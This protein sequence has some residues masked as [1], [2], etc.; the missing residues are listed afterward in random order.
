[1]SSL[2]EREYQVIRKLVFERSRINL[3]PDKKELVA[4][5]VNKRLRQLRLDSYADYC[6]LLTASDGED[7]LKDLVDVISTNFTNFFRE[8]SHFDFLRA[9]AL[10]RFT[11]GAKAPIKRLRV[12]SAACSSGE[13]PYSIAI[14]L[15]D[16]FS[17]KDGWQWQVEAA[18]ISTRMLAKAR[19]GIYEAARVI[20][21]NP[22][23]L[24]RYFRK[25]VDSYAGYYRVKAELRGAVRFHHLNLFQP[26]YPFAPGLHAIFCRNVMI[27][28]DRATQEQLVNRLA[29]YLLPGGYLFVGHAESLI[30][31]NHPLDGIEPS[32]YQKPDRQHG[33]LQ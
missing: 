30:S 14:V 27:Y 1:M 7:E 15:A 10:P 16:F 12:W 11:A 6:K 13:E 32:V 19:C 8:R 5:R 17:G 18:D 20:L 29:D 23:W 24:R 9:T 33:R 21:P 25:G 3:G 22:G 28:F 31:I 2:H 4:V 26:D